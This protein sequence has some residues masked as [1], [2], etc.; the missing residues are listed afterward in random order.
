MEISSA[1]LGAAVH[2]AVQRNVL[3]QI[4]AQGA[5]LVGLIASAPAPTGSVNLP[6]QGQLLDVRV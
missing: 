5:G 4:K 6:S 1:Q 2:V 3:D